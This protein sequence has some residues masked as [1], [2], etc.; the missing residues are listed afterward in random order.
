MSNGAAPS[1]INACTCESAS[2]I[3]AF[4]YLFFLPEFIFKIEWSSIYT[5]SSMLEAPWQQRSIL[6]SEPLSFNALLSL[7]PLIWKVQGTESLGCDTDLLLLGCRSWTRY[8]PARCMATGQSENCMTTRMALSGYPAS[9]RPASS[10][11]QKTI[12][13]L[14]QGSF[15]APSPSSSHTVITH[16]SSQVETWFFIGLGFRFSHR[17]CIPYAMIHENVVL[18]PTPLFCACPHFREAEG[19][20]LGIAC[21]VS[22]GRAQAAMPICFSFMSDIPSHSSSRDNEPDLTQSMM[23]CKAGDGVQEQWLCDFL[24][25]SV[26]QSLCPPPELVALQIFLAGHC[27]P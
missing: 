27:R 14:T 10:S 1:C 22:L 16:W 11:Q 23:Q 6:F 2:G 21:Q 17:S 13:S 24:L 9:G 8:L 12:R 4:V 26:W 5:L 15:K 18:I 7:T 3:I 19:Q 20:V 25:Y